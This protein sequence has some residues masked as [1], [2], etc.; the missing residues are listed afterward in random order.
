M[1]RIDC[2]V[3]TVAILGGL[4]DETSGLN[5]LL[6]AL[7]KLQRERPLRIVWGVPESPPLE[8][9]LLAEI[10]PVVINSPGDIV[11]VVKQSD[12]LALGFHSDQARR[13]ALTAMTC[14]TAVVVLASSGIQDLCMD[15][16]TALVVPARDTNALSRAVRALLNDVRLR[17]RLV[18]AGHRQAAR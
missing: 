18:V 15:G 10:E 6:P 3:P 11:H 14:G 17:R 5:I 16:A 9:E 8:V 13:M 2:L 1:A 12:V 4:Y 7:G